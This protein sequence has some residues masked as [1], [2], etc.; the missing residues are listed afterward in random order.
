MHLYG[1]DAARRSLIDTLT[2]RIASQVATTL[3]YIVLVRGMQDEAFGVY[4]LLYAF[5]PLVSTFASLGL[6]QIL[7]RY[8]PEYLQAGKYAAA[9]WLFRFI[10]IARFASNFVILGAILLAWQIVSPL[11]KMEQYRGEFAFFCLIVLLYFQVV[12]FSSRW[13]RTCSTASR[14]GRPRSWLCSN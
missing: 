1:R 10:E 9:T 4:N 2:Y 12:F 5:I 13:L 7:R 3:G 6:E 14:S 11:L 8:Q